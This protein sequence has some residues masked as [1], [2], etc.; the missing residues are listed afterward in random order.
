MDTMWTDTTVRSRQ[1]FV[2][3]LPLVAALA[4]SGFVTVPAAWAQMTSVSQ[5]NAGA[6]GI[7]PPSTASTPSSSKAA[8][9]T[10]AAGA[11][12]PVVLPADFSRL[13][14]APGDLL[15]VNIYDTPEM[16]DSYRVGADG[17]LSF[18]LIGKVRVQGLTTAQTARL[19]EQKL[20]DGQI[21]NHPQV[22]V[23]VLQYAGQF[24]T[25]IGEVAVPGKVTVIAP[26]KLSEVLAQCGGL[27]ATAGDHI[28]IRHGEDAGGPETDVVF[29]RSASNQKAG[30]ILLRPGDTVIVPRAGIVYVLGAVL[31]PGGYVMQE[32]GELNVAQALAMSGGTALQAKT[33]GL[34]VIRRGPNGTVEVFQLSYD[35]IVKGS[36]IPLQ[37]RAEDIVY[38]PV[39]KFKAS[40]LDATAVISSAASASIYVAADR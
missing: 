10:L 39:S 3:A 22:N 35:G 20:R 26:T 34:R 33:G 40:M 24:V 9:A 7:A 32:D 12:G 1:S 19:L 29:R 2:V 23:I 28:K 8:T 16:T 15:S 30:N 13:R 14:V 21:L 38:V 11:A 4:L 36:Q 27:T 31:R 18:P 5:G 17:S 6:N 37:L 25:V